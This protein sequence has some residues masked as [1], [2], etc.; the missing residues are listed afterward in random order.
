MKYQSMRIVATAIAIILMCVP[1]VVFAQD[2]SPDQVTTAAQE[3]LLRHPEMTRTDVQYDPHAV[4]V[5]FKDN[6]TQRSMEQSWNTVQA[7]TVDEVGL[8]DGL[9]KIDISDSRMDIATTIGLL[10][11]MP[12]VEFAEPDYVVQPTETVPNDTR[13]TELWGLSSNNA[14]S[15]W[16]AFT[17]DPNFIVAMIDS[18]MD[19]THPDLA[20][21][22]WTNPGEIAGNGIDDDH[23]GYID[24]IHGWDF[25]DSDNDPMDATNHGTHTAGIVGAT[26]NNSTGVVG[27]NWHCKI[28]PLRFLGANGGYTSDAVKAINYAVAKGVKISNHSWG[29]GGYST[30]LYNAINAARTKGHLLIAAAGNGGT[31]QV[32]DSNDTVPFYPAS[33]ALDNIISVAA[34]SSTDAKASFSNYGATSVDLGA[35][36]VSILST[37]P[38]SS[39]GYASGTSMASPYV[40]GTAA[41]LWGANPTWTYLEV[42]TRILETAREVPSLSGVT[43]T[44]AILD[45]Q[46]ALL[47]AAPLAVTLADF[48]AQGE[49]DHI[50]VSWETVTETDNLGFNLYRSE[51]VDGA[52]V[53]VNPALIP[54]KAPGSS[55]GFA[56]EWQD[57]DVTEGSN[58]YYWLEDVDL[59]GKTTGRDP[60][61]A[62]LRG[63]SQA[64][65]FFPVFMQD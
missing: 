27:M 40:A 34:V 28:M 58:Y 48:T 49:T 6:A 18:G 23:N 43:T 60:I 47:G 45:A 46:A 50:V 64:R 7:E 57:F 29:T 19:Y 13:Y 55:D 41:L 38:N 36:G 16:D 32:G 63:P 14:P 37:L 12:N 65:L 26:G 8:T 39:Y 62:A 1:T 35:P 59:A 44:G 4:L 54:A 33:F 11:R 17:G 30:A 61:Q 10:E 52:R 2:G 51:T 9:V 53:Q 24:D 15:A 21:N 25:Y 5:Q 3:A 42:K 20:G 31:D 22:L 56:Y